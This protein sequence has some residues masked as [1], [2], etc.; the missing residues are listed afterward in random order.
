MDSLDYKQDSLSSVHDTGN[1]DYK[2]AQSLA[3]PGMDA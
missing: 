1:L 2:W 3:N